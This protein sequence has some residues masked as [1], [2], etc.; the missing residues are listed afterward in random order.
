MSKIKLNL[1]NLPVQEK[2]AKARTIITSLTGNANFP[3]PTPTPTLAIVTSATDGLENVG[4]YA[5]NH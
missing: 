2:I 5:A 4:G 1:R 3:T